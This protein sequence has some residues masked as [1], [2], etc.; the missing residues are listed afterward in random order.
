M[1]INRRRFRIIKEIAEG[2]FGKVYL[3]EQ[4]SSDGFSRIVAIKL[5][6]SKW[7]SHDE[8]VKR[9][10]D[11]A[12]VLGKIRHQHIVKVEDLTS[13]EGKAA[14]VMEYLEGVDLKWMASF[15]KDKKLE[16]SRAA[17]FEIVLAVSSA[18]DAAYNAVPLQGGEPLRAIHRDIKPSNIFV[19]VAGGVKVL[20]FGTAR[21]NFAEREAK[22]QQL[23]FGSQGYM[24]PERMLGEEDT[25][26]ADVFSLGITLYELLTL[27]SFGRIP[28]RPNKFAKKVEERVAAV[29]LTGDP[30]WVTQVRDT[31]RLMLSYAPAERP[32]AAQLVEIM[33]LLAQEAND[34]GLR[35]YCRTLVQEAKDALPALDTGDPLTGTIVDEDDSGPAISGEGPAQSTMALNH[36]SLT[37]NPGASNQGSSAQTTLPPPTSGTMQRP[38]VVA[39]VA[40]SQTPSG[41]NHPP[42]PVVGPPPK[43][44]AVKTVVPKTDDG[45]DTDVE[46]IPP[47]ISA[48]LPS[49]ND[50]AAP[51]I[52]TTTSASYIPNG[53]AQGGV[54][55]VV[56]VSADPRTDGGRGGGMRAIGVLVVGILVVAIAIGVVAG[57]IVLGTAVVISSDGRGTDAPT[58]GGAT[59]GAGTEPAS[60]GRIVSPDTRL[61]PGGDGVATAPTVLRYPDPAGANIEILGPSG[62]RAVWDGKAEFDLGAVGDGEYKCSIA[63]PTGRKLRLK[64]F[65]VV[66]GSA[67][68]TF[69]FAPATEDW[70]G[71]CE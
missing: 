4:I 50:S 49:L 62:F 14:I 54:P 7:S 28:P 8:V 52:R 51:T 64:N 18:M 10:R 45:G 23:A 38:G 17:L 39:V 15:L 30:E 6:H 65:K 26:A 36:G 69:V 71:A 66:G 32:S 37:S 42:P 55:A 60:G 35:R 16:F 59:D 68:C 40:G 44:P 9:T 70:T 25:P 29:S 41:P 47:V 2:G 48:S 12:R 58:D 22:T 24:A 34:T 57:V 43:A 21:A 61:V 27:E 3:A 46:A 53:S 67:G 63:P 56:Q 13:I 5:L 31:L 20:D 33:D 11:E 19:T 1:S